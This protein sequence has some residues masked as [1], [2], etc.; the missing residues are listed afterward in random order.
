[1]AVFPDCFSKENHLKYFFF[2]SRVT[3]TSKTFTDQKKLIAGSAIQ[4][5]INYALYIYMYVSKPLYIHST[6]SRGSPN[7]VLCN[8]GCEHCYMIRSKTLTPS[9]NKLQNETHFNRS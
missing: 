5:L 6:I 7:E 9:L 3:P 8:T 2:I 1:M 4:L